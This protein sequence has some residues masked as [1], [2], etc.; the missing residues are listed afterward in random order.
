MLY[1]LPSAVYFHRPHTFF[2]AAGGL[3]GAQHGVS[4]LPASWLSALENEA[5]SG[6]EAV[7]QLALQLAALDCRV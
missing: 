5:G 3:A 2:V 7:V 6:R 4:W 1:G